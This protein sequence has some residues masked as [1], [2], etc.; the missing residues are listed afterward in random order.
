MKAAVICEYGDASVFALEDVADPV[1]GLGE[2]VVDLRAASV[3]RRDRGI[4]AGSLVPRAI[5][6]QSEQQPTFPLILGSDGA[7]VVSEVGVG[8][9]GVAVG[10]EVVINPS[11]NW[12]ERDESPGPDWETLGVPRQGTYAE[13]IAVPA[14]FIAPKPPRLTW[15]EAAVV[16]LAGLTA[17]R[18]VVTKARVAA[19]ERVLVPGVGSG[20]ATFVVQFAQ[21]LGC[22]VVVTSSSEEKLARAREIGAADGLLYTAPDWPARV[23]VVDV[24]ID[25]IG[26]PI[27]SALGEFLRPGGRMVSYGRTAGS[28][29]SLE[30]ARVFHAQWTLLGT[31]NGSPAEF[32]AMIE[33]LGAS[34]WRPVIDSEYSLEEISQAHARLES[35]ERFG[36]VAIAIAS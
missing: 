17:W 30:I 27:W 31:A 18:A 35:P 4:R 7:G 9:G 25:S 29:V 22:E 36:K 14:A 3:N 12:G 15:Y 28:V 24:V 21:A 6:G 23:G 19:G 2:V 26:E 34:D 20:V 32:A 10:D 11:L 8:V 13:R 33:H 16:P 1:P 5:G